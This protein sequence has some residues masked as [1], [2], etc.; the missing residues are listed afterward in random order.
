MSK[1]PV[2]WQVKKMDGLFWVDDSGCVVEAN[3]RLIR[4]VPIMLHALREVARHQDVFCG[5]PSTKAIV[6][7]AIENATG[8]VV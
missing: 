4:A 8:E 1:L 2:C 3:E 5:S 6:A 7:Q